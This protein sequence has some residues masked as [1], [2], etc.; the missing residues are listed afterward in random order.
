MTSFQSVQVYLDYLT[1]MRSFVRSVA[2]GTFSRAAEEAGVKVSTIS[3]YVA[4]LE[5]DLGAALLNRSTHGLHLTEIGRMFYEQ[6][7]RIVLEVDDA[8]RL[9]SAFNATPQGCLKITVPT[10]FGRLHVMP[11]I[12]AFLA[13]HPAISLDVT[14]TDSHVD[15]IEAGVDLAMRIGALPD[16]G[17][18]ARKLAP[19]KRI[20]CASPELLASAVPIEGPADLVNREALVFSI[21]PAT[22]HFRHRATGERVAIKVSG[23]IKIND[24][25]GLL[26]CARA[27]LGVAVLPTWLVHADLGRGALV[28]PLTDWEAGLMP[29]FDRA[30]WAVYPPKKVV[31]PKVRA[32]I[33]FFEA[34]YR[35]PVFWETGLEQASIAP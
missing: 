1:A 2:L 22:W 13:E 23:R 19:H 11:H 12:S 26:T 35:S 5:E 14:L 8:R 16:S 30:I 31:S 3:R 21:H 34:R 7:A 17:L 18:I 20:F 4:S 32:F 15:L 25:E 10:A 28:A 29:D 33:S 9:A 27:G 6:A 24:S